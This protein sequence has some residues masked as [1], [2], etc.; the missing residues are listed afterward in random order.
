MPSFRR[1]HVVCSSFEFWAVHVP[2]VHETNASI[3]ICH[4]LLVCSESFEANFYGSCCASEQIAPPKAPTKDQLAAQ[5]YAALSPLA[6]RKLDAEKKKS[7][8]SHS[9]SCING[10]WDTRPF[11]PAST[12]EFHHFLHAL[13][14]LLCLV[15][16]YVYSSSHNSFS[17]SGQV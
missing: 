13:F 14:F 15:L 12:S 17:I 10:A 5:E 11:T 2:F 7:K 6:R 8:V 16:C 9:R 3:F 1:P 4:P